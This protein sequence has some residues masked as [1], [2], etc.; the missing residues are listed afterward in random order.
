MQYLS[1]ADNCNMLTQ[2]DFYMKNALKLLRLH[3]ETLES[4]NRHR[5]G[6]EQRVIVQHVQVSEGG[7]AIVNNGSMTAGM[8][9]VNKKMSEVPHGHVTNM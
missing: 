4:L 6:G 5:R 1:K 9:G 7:Q 3:N 2:S 8:G